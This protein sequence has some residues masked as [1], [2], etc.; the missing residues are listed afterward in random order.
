VPYAALFRAG[1]I[2]FRRGEPLPLKSVVDEAVA[3]CPSVKN[4][5]VV[6]RFRDRRSSDVQ[7]T[8]GRDIWYW[9]IARNESIHCPCEELDSEDMA[10][11]L[12][13]SGSTGKPKGVMHT[14][15]GYMVFTY[16][17][18]RYVFDLKDEDVYWCT[19][20]IGWITGHSYIVYG[21]MQNGATCLMY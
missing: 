5:L 16:L 9:D 18:S 8:E 20:D 2:G 6:E 12:Y 1:D 13:T 17:T 3:E 15:G 11:L 4:V 19:A 14:V 21:P 7:I 10:F